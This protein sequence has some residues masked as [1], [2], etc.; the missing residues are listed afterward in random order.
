MDRHG[1][2]RALATTSESGAAA[3]NPNISWTG[4]RL[5]WT[6]TGFRPN[7]WSRSTSKG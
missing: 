3:T 4:S 6:T 7:A 5:V 2:L 1:A